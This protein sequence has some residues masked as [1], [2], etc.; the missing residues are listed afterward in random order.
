MISQNHSGF[1]P[2]DSCRNQLLTITHEV[3]KFFDACLDVR[4]VFLDISK[5]FDKV[6]HQGLLYKLKWNGISSKLLETWT[7]SLEDRKERVI[8]NG[9]NSSWTNAE[10]GVPQGSILSRLLFLIYI[11]DL[12]DNL[13][14]NV[15][16]VADDTSLFSV[17]HDIATSS[18]EREWA[19]QWKLSFNPGPSKQAQEVT[20]THQLQKKDYPLL[21]FIDSS[22]KETCKQKHLGMLLDFRL[23]F[24]E[25]ILKSLLK[26]VNKTVTL[27][28]K[29]QNIRPRS[30]LLT[31]YKCFVRT[32]L[33]YGDIIYDQAFTN[34]F[35]Q[36]IE[37]LHYNAALAITGVTRGMTR[38]KNNQE[39]GSESLQQ[40]CIENC[41]FFKI[42]KNQCPKYLFGIIPQSNCQY[43][44]RNTHNITNINMK[45]QFFKNLLFS[46]NHN[47]MKQ[48]RF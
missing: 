19:F 44:T 12:P 21:Y 32:H 41:L 24:Q 36:K 31:I 5:A 18:C 39:L 46:I 6:W 30:A 4:A 38:E 22:V 15:K 17:V 42:Y 2:G 35:H 14:R 3:Y 7:D 26:K 48:I 47:R 9:Y 25:E 45:Y 29:F 13:W 10:A 23:D 37:S 1:K 27:W 20:Y 8:L 33:D 28:R 16:L 43:R 11:N 34:S 40:S